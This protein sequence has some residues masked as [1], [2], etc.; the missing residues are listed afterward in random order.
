VLVLAA[1]GFFLRD[2]ELSADQA[3]QTMGLQLAS[4]RERVGKLEAV[5]SQVGGAD[6][7]L[8]DRIAALE[9][10][11]AALPKEG[12][13]AAVAPPAAGPAPEELAKR[14]AA[15]E[16]KPAPDTAPLEQ[17]IAALEAARLA[18][19]AETNARIEALEK[20]VK[21]SVKP[22]LAGL[23]QTQPLQASKADLAAVLSRIAGLEAADERPLAKAAASALAVSVLS[24]AVK[25]GTPYEEELGAVTHLAGAP[26]P[27]QPALDT[28]SRQAGT[29]IPSQEQLIASFPAAAHAARAADAP[30]E[31]GMMGAIRRSLGDLVSFRMPG[32]STESALGAMDKALKRDDIAEAL[33]AAQGLEPRAKAA[34][35]PWLARARQRQSALAAV[36]TL[37]SAAI[38]TLAT[39]SIQ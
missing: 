11:L 8:K 31:S 27:A 15:L 34:L 29:G 19:I 35:E 6:S 1:V 36:T 39:T 17:R 3:K 16:A 4:L 33:R 2:R 5:S 18:Q 14:I 7:T 32:A 37:R 20:D 38:R 30:R 10:A 23:A 9:A 25:A 28:L 26:A 22:T 12:V 13:P 24:D 21:E